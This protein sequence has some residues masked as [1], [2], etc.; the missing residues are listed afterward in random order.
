[1]GIMGVVGFIADITFG[2]LIA[3]LGY[4][5]TFRNI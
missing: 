4:V 3:D 2:V 5:S 1:M